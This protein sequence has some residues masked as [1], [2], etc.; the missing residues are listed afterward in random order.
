MSYTEPEKIYVDVNALK[1]KKR[2]EGEGY[3][4]CKTVFHFEYDLD[5]DYYFELI[6]HFY[7]TQGE[8]SLYEIKDIELLTEKVFITPEMGLVKTDTKDGFMRLYY[9]RPTDEFILTFMSD[10][11]VFRSAHLLRRK[12]EL[13]LIERMKRGDNK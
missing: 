1:M 8:Y 2:S 4:E 11:C 7:L 9:N 5:V 10:L 3:K 6:R 12:T 13:E